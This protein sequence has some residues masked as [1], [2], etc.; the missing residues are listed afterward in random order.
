VLAGNWSVTGQQSLSHA[1][2][3]GR[4]GSTPYCTTP[5]CGPREVVPEPAPLAM[6][7]LALFAIGFG[8]RR[9]GGAG[10]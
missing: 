5:D 7:S 6:L 8:A 9:F 4:A 2:L 10:S 3:Y 1:N